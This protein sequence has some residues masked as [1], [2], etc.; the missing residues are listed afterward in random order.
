MIDLRFAA[1]ALGG[2]VYNRRIVCPGPN[3]SR[4]DR[5]LS[6][7]FDASA[8]DGFLLYSHAGDNFAACRDHVRERLRLENLHKAQKPIAR[9]E[10][11]KAGKVGPERTSD[12]SALALRIWREAQAAA[13]SPVAA[14]LASRGLIL[15]DGAHEV[16]RY[17][18][19]CPFAGTRTPAMVA[20]VR[21]VCTDAPQAIHRT[22][23]TL[24][25]QK[26]VVNGRD[27]LALGPLAGGAV[28][29]TASAEVTYCIGVGEGL[30]STLSLRGLPEF[31]G[32]PVWALLNTAGVTA[33]MPLPGIESLWLAVDHD[34]GGER[35]ANACGE[36]W[37]RAGKEVFLV[38]ATAL[39][40]DLNDIAKGLANG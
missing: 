1:R 37:R 23:I 39:G 2:E 5:S 22:A 35:A 14:Y 11:I 3:H 33:F 32:T 16:I 10:P 18:P 15:P 31:G 12:R 24:E 19:A 17:A 26:S 36:R 20:L 38:T 40:Q 30:E 7:L 4:H 13:D 6:I 34:P 27:R 8:P 21:N 9:P 28:M 29:L 25:G